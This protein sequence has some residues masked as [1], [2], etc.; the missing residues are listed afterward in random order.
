M[1]TPHGLSLSVYNR[2]NQ[3]GWNTCTGSKIASI[4]NP[5]AYC[6]T[7]RRTEFM[8]TASLLQF[9]DEP[10]PFL[11]YP[12]FLAMS[13]S[14][15]NFK[16]A[17]RV[18]PLIPREAASGTTQVSMLQR[19]TD[20]HDLVVCQCRLVELAR[21]N[22]PLVCCLGRAVLCRTARLQDHWAGIV[23]SPN[24]HVIMYP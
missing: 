18:R 10:H 12:L 4:L 5:L 16:V 11:C 19:G 6:Y 8:E 15:E 22:S 2:H 14:G 17:V 13:A 9:E 23:G 7:V 24:L 21:C 3:R 1:S 20:A